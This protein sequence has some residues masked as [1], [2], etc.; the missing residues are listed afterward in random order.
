MKETLWG[1]GVQ[2]HGEVHLESPSA[3]GPILLLTHAPNPNVLL[4]PLL[5]ECMSPGLCTLAVLLNS[6]FRMP[7]HLAAVLHNHTPTQH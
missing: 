2:I 6:V 5:S 7:E 3:S 4:N 1:S